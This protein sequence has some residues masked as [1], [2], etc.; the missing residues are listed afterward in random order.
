MLNIDFPHQIE[1]V[2]CGGIIFLINILT[3]SFLDLGEITAAQ[4]M[5]DS[6]VL[7]HYSLINA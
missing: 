4:G 5:V 3:T 7:L 1:E 2:S 6:A